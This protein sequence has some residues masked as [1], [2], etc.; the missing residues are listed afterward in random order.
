M[1]FVDPNEGVVGSNPFPENKTT[2]QDI[3]YMIKGPRRAISAF[4]YFC[5]EQRTNLQDVGELWKKLPDEE[6]Q[7]YKMMAA[8]DKMRFAREKANWEATAGLQV[9]Y[10][11]DPNTPPSS[12]SLPDENVL[13]HIPMAI[14]VE[15]LSLTHSN[16]N[17]IHSDGLLYILFFL[18]H[19]FLFN[20]ME[21]ICEK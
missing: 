11:L 21:S 7:K 16:D 13:T 3:K 17:K 20:T 2:V 6:K 18:F 10:S 9:D 1:F 14:P 5:N 15:S 8:Q 4:L 12:P 19:F